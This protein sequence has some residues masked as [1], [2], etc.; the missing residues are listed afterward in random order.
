MMLRATEEGLT[1]SD[2][3]QLEPPFTVRTMASL[4]IA[5]HVVALTHAGDTAGNVS[6]V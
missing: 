6:E 4:S 3:V 2:V 5:R 1:R